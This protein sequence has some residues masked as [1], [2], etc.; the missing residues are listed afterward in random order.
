MALCSDVDDVD[1]RTEVEGT[2]LRCVRTPEGSPT[3][4]SHGVKVILVVEEI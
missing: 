2:I 1:C 4:C 3:A